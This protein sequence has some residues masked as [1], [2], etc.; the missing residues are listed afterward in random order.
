MSFK[1]FGIHT[2]YNRM[3][4]AAI[5]SKKEASFGAE[6]QLMALPQNNPGF[7]KD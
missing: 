5:K 7:P 1:R 6:E 4:E 3:R 2:V